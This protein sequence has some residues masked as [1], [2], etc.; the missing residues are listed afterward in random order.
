VYQSS[1]QGR[2]PISPLPTGSL[3]EGVPIDAKQIQAAPALITT[4]KNKSCTFRANPWTFFC[5]T[6]AEQAFHK[7]MFFGALLINMLTILLKPLILHAL[8]A[9]KIKGFSKMAQVLLI[10]LG[11]KGRGI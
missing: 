7:K 2:K 8:H 3:E 4:P 10:R 6:L 9:R 1:W 11:I 5:E